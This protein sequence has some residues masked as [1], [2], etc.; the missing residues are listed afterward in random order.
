MFTKIFLC[1]FSWSLLSACDGAA[2]SEVEVPVF[3]VDLNT[4]TKKA[5]QVAGEDT[6]DCG[7]VMLDD[8]V[9][10]NTVDC[11]IAQNLAQG[12]PFYAVYEERHINNGSLRGRAYIYNGLGEYS[13]HTWD[14][15]GSG[16]FPYNKFGCEIIEVNEN[17]CSVPDTDFPYCVR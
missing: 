1:L 12:L 5:K 13:A 10:K 14:S 15:G 2:D 9:N 11:C 7:Y 4:L 17:I 6:I 3:V 8:D 16:S